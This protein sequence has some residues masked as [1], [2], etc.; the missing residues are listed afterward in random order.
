MVC[1]ISGK[2]SCKKPASEGHLFPLFA[3]IRAPH[4]LAPETE[5][6][7]VTL[8]SKAFSARYLQIPK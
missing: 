7:W 5:D 8:L 1:L 3:K 6:M 4:R 2:T